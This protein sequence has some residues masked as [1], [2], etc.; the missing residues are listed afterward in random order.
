[1][2]ASSQI[3]VFLRSTHTKNTKT[4]SLSACAGSAS[5][6]GPARTPARP[7]VPFCA[8]SLPFPDRNAAATGARSQKASKKRRIEVPKGHSTA[9]HVPPQQGGA[10]AEEKGFEPLVPFGTAVFKTA[11]FDHSATPP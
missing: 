11:A 3:Q 8:T 7:A 1:M 2:N 10:T 9:S 4:K 6:A 5:T